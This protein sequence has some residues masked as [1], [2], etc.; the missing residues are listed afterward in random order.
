MIYTVLKRL[1][2]LGRIDG[3][4]VKLDVFYAAGKLTE[5]EYAELTG[6][7]PSIVTNGE[8]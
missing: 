2:D 1:I 8:E 7:L 4:E 5:Q 6:L 3:L